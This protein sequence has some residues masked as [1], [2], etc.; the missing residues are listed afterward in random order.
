MTS[1][2]T[3]VTKPWHAVAGETDAPTATKR[4]L[5][6]VG[7]GCSCVWR[8][9]GC[10]A[11]N[12]GD[13]TGFLEDS[14]Q[15]RDTVRNYDSW[16]QQLPKTTSSTIKSVEEPSLRPNNMPDV[17]RERNRVH[18]FGCWSCLFLTLT[19]YCWQE[20]DSRSL[21]NSIQSDD[22]VGGDDSQDQQL[23]ETTS[24]TTE[25]CD[26]P[27]LRPKHMANISRDTPPHQDSEP[28]II[29]WFQRPDDD[30]DL[31]QDVAQHTTKERPERGDWELMSL[32]SED[33][34]E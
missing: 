2:V 30:T 6:P 4:Q 8:E 7:A 10:G 17:C 31:P 34:V 11:S 16:D 28:T 1:Q 19:C 13:G 24:S 20:V 33:M 9:S 23:S 22:T 27:S 12:I 5:A 15:S 21:E 29:V 3:C 26:E 25:S 32:T 18:K 14:V